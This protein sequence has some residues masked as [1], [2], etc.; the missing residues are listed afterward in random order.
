[1]IV[2]PIVYKLSDLK[3]EDLNGI[4]YE[5]ELSVFNPSDETSYKIEKIIG[6]TTIKGINYV[7]VK[8]KG[9]PDK[10]NEWI[11]KANII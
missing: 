6:K 3:G 4:F 1:M 8:Y 2:N 9:W 5:N 7:L 10:F 11:P